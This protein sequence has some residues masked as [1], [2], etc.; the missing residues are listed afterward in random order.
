[1]TRQL[2]AGAYGIVALGTGLVWIM[3]AVPGTGAE[4][5]QPLKRVGTISSTVILSGG[6]DRQ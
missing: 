3:A 1:M 5:R 2:R 6:R 4:E